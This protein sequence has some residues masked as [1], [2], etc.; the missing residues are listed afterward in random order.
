MKSIYRSI[1]A[2]SVI[3]G[4]ASL[5]FMMM[6]AAGVRA[7][8]VIVEGADGAAGAD[9]VNP[10]DPGLSGGDGE[11]RPPMRGACTQSPSP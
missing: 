6:G 2:R 9:G 8:I 10:G 4:A 5:A 1:L 7:E 11:S 3:T